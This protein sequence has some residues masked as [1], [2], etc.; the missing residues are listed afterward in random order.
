MREKNY[1][2]AL[3]HL[4]A[5]EVLGARTI[6]IDAGVHEDSFTNEQFDWIVKRY[7]EYAQRA[8]DHGCKV[9]PENH[10]GAEAAPENMQRLC[11]AV[12]HPGFGMLLHFRGNSGDA[13][14]APWAMHTHLSWDICAQ[15]LAES[16]AMLRASGY[17]GCWGVEHHSGQKEYTE[18][19]IMAARVHSVLEDW[20]SGA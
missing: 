3:A 7:K 12:D 13:L 2:N 8:Y 1:Q 9:G 11:Q 5:A 4:H 10:W 19:A 20:A 16:M 17:K 15:N 14:M 6:R 18:V